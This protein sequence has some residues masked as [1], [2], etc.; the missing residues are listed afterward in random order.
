MPSMSPGMSKLVEKQLR[1]WEIARSQRPTDAK[2][3]PVEVAD[4]LALSRAVGAGGAAGADIAH[5]V[6]QKLGWPVF[7]KEIL[8]AMAADDPTRE[9][10]YKSM[11]ERDIGWV[12]ESLRALMQGAFK[13]NDYF[14]RLTEAVLAIARQGPAVFRGR[15]ADLI[16]PRARGFRVRLTASR[17][18]CV[19]NYAEHHNCDAEQ[20]STEID[21]IGTERADFVRKHF[22]VEAS[23]ESRHDLTINL[24]SF[25][26]YQAVELIIT[27][28]ETRGTTG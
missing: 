14:H 6:G 23:Q 10:L 24:E 3:E 5:A 17:E 15:A 28:M 22:G 21:R 7:N 4:F 25:S 12:E 8:Q 1:N 19:K 16:L 11:D 13:K 20:A 2:A 18:H 9:R 26:A 27:G